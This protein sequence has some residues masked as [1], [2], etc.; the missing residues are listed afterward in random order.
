M[1][2]LRNPWLDRQPLAA[3]LHPQTKARSRD[4]WML[5]PDIQCAVRHQT[6]ADTLATAELLLKLWPKLLVELPQPSVAAVQALAA[7]RRWL[8]L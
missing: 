4:E 3:V 1:P 8:P 6:A 2:A 7:Q 5:A